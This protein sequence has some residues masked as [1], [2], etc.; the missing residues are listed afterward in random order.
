MRWLNRL[1]IKSKLIV[2]LL[3]VSSCSIL[4]TSYLGYRSGKSNLTERVFSQLTSLRASKA[5]QIEFYFDNI[6]N[7]IQTLSVDPA[8]I[9]AMTE[10]ASSY[11]QLEKTSVSPQFQQQLNAYYRDEFLPRLT[12]TEQGSPVLNS[13]IPENA[14]A[15]YL[16][17][18]YLAANPQPVGKKHLWN[19]SQDNSQYNRIHAR[20]HAIFRDIILKFGYYDL[21][22]ID[23]QGTIVYT[24]LVAK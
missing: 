10:F 6:R 22:L 8:V 4:V 9:A 16:Q 17:Y 1:S 19:R 2:M 11:R 15:L 7:H 20:Y 21:F 23:P 3:T 24:R 5:Y 14:A 18:Y 13:F 12:K